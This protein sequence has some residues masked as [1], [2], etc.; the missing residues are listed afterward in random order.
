MT[1]LSYGKPIPIE[2]NKL[3]IELLVSE[4][5]QIKKTNLIVNECYTKIE[6][7]VLSKVNLFGN[8]YKTMPYLISKLKI[9]ESYI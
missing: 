7:N 4:K 8:I 1:P 5:L 2:L 9:N 3:S 6:I